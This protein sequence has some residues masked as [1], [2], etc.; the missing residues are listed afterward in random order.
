[1]S[2][3]TTPRCL[4]TLNLS[5][6]MS[7]TSNTAIYMY[8]DTTKGARKRMKYVD[9]RDTIL[10]LENSGGRVKGPGVKGTFQQVIRGV[11]N[12]YALTG[13]AIVK[14]STTRPVSTDPE[15]HVFA[16]LMI[17]VVLPE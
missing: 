11:Q 4:S 9:E 5:T 2:V 15:V 12:I 7:S 6:S 10:Y 14:P 13:I 3:D 16:K 8:F 17:L 1:M